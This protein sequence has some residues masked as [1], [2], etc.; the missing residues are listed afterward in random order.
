MRFFDVDEPSQ[1]CAT[2]SC[3]I[4]RLTIHFAASRCF[5]PVLQRRP[6]MFIGFILGLL[7]AK[8]AYDFLKTK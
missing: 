5:N 7:V 4:G 6:I 1:V 3:C 8:V 2:G